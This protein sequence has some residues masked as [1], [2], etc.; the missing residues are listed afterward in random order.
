MTG[1]ASH[2]EPG[3]R[4]PVALPLLFRE[5]ARR[6]P[7]HP[8]VDVPPGKDRPVRHVTTYAELLAASD[9]IAWRLRPLASGESLVAILLPRDSERLYAAQLGVLSA[10]AAY[11]CLDVAFPDGQARDVLADAEP[12]ALLTDAAGAERARSAGWRAGE[13]VDVTRIEPAAAPFEPPA[14]DPGSLAYVIYTSGT[15]GQPKGVMIEHRS[16]ASLVESDRVEFALGPGDR[17]AQGSSPAYDSSLEEVWLAFAAGGTVVVADE[18]AVRLGPDLVP[19]LRRE[20]ITVLC[21][22][23]TLLR[24]TGCADPASALP[25]LRLLY[26]GGEALTSDVADRWAPGRRLENGYGPTECTVTCLRAPVLAG[27]A[28]TIG[29][30]VPGM[31]AWVLGERGEELGDG[32]RGELC[33]GGV[34]L[35]RGYRNR[36]DVTSA[37]FPSHPRLGRIYRTGDLVHREPD[38]RHVY[39]GRLDAQV[40][41]RGYRIELE[42]VETRLAEC[43]GVREAAC[44]VQGEGARGIL[45]AFVVPDGDGPAPDAARLRALLGRELPAYMVPARLAVVPELPK[46]VGGKLDRR[47]LPVVD[48]GAGR[49]PVA[50]RNP[51]EASI[52]AAIRL[53]LPGDGPVSV[54][55]DFFADVGGDSLAAA[56][57]ISLLREDP[58]TAGLTVRDVYE[59][60][61]VEGLA[62]LAVRVSPTYADAPSSPRGTS[63]VPAAPAGRARPVV[64][65]ALQAGWLLVVLVLAAAPAWWLGLRVLTALLAR[66][67]LLP[68]LLLA[69]ALATLGLTAYAGAAVLVVV[70]LKRLLVGRYVP[71]RV[72]IWSAFHVRHWMVVQATRLLPW[73]LLAGTFLQTWT[74][75]ALGARVGDR[76]HFH[77]GVNLLQGGWDLLEIGDDATIS[78]DASLHVADVESG[79]LV[80]GPVTVGAGALVDV[81]AGMAP[82][83]ALGARACLGPLAHLPTGARVPDGERWD[84][85]PAR[86]AGPAAP[87]PVLPQ[88]ASRLSAIGYGLALLVSRVLLCSLF[89]LP[90]ELLGFGAAR[91][92]GIDGTGVAAWLSRPTAGS[93]LLLVLAVLTLVAGPPTLALM[94][95]AARALGRVTAGAI[96][97]WS[98]DYLRVWLK[99]GLVQLAGDWLSGTLLWPVWLRAAGMRVGPGCEIS[100][101]LDVVPELVEVGPGSFLA[102]GIYLGGPRVSRGTVTLAPVSLAANTFLGNHVVIPAGERLPEDVLVG[103]CTVG[104]DEYVQPGTSWFGQPPFELPRREVV[105][106]DRSLTHEPSRLRYWNRVFWELA[107]FLLPAGPALAL[108][109]WLEALAEAQRRLPPMAFATLGVAAATLGVTLA[110]ILLVLALKWALLGRVKPGIH[111]LWSCW[112]SRWDFL[113]VVWAVYARAALGALE[114]TL[115]LTSYLRAMGMRIGRDVVLGPGFAQVVD[116]DM[117]ELGDGSTVSALFQAHTFED[118]VLKIDR[119]TIRAGAT[120]GSGAVLLYGADVG[121]GTRVAPHSVVM[122][123]EVLL[124]GRSYEGCPTRESGAA[125]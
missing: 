115:L 83:T 118:R 101:I 99:T 13:I 34:G 85:V 16:I 29:R 75:R 38:G 60:R 15:T 65:T 64:A 105:A 112:C 48:D 6:F 44:T 78:Q 3:P 77:R 59:A 114:G 117:L 66:L 26:V 12:V 32:E 57:L 103:V 40:K 102:D 82:G 90:L 88:D 37:K 25:E 51:R 116:P 4:P 80:I 87:A 10:G 49:D 92:S 11:T 86:P 84:G 98:L 33:L 74:L 76:V 56:Q 69:P 2:R 24:T 14:I 35:A 72:P 81:R 30:P 19:W 106:C 110:P 39:H 43:P 107:R 119:V 5:T 22:P 125:A 104:N 121:E 54:L 122:K 41:L 36:P 93:R 79:D 45:V 53:V 9:A 91:L 28:I 62:R 97:R 67:G 50:P 58:A 42:A 46:S 73:R 47:R 27:E 113:Y 89:A 123:R 70:A 8:A 61:T 94:A 120:V 96:P 100:T 21:P 20:R 23:P 55:D 95:L 1:R 18:E 108:V 17:V 31:T 109:L 124:P 68:C 71:A 52:A 111:P 7:D 63:A